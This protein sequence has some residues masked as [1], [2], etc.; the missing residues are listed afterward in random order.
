TA[1]LLSKPGPRPDEVADLLDLVHRAPVRSSEDSP[2]Q[3]QRHQQDQ[4][5]SH[6]PDDWRWQRLERQPLPPSLRAQ[7]IEPAEIRQP[8]WLPWYAKSEGELNEHH[9]GLDE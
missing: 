6:A 7:R 5:G 9:D 1:Q 3:E 2:R 8:K 4:R